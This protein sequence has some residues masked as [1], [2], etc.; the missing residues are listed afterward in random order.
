MRQSDGQANP[1]LLARGENTQETFMCLETSIGL[2]EPADQCRKNGQ[3]SQTPCTWPYNGLRWDVSAA[4]DPLHA[5]TPNG[6][7][8]ALTVSCDCP[9]ASEADRN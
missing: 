4:T 5:K 7:T 1:A 6:E 2:F 9:E 3:C 8:G